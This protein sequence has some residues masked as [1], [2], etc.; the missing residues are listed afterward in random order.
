MLI[1]QI[2]PAPRSSQSPAYP[3]RHNLH[4]RR[5]G[6]SAPGLLYAQNGASAT[7]TEI[8]IPICQSVTYRLDPTVDVPGTLRRR[9][10]IFRQTHDLGRFLRCSSSCGP[11]FRRPGRRGAP[12]SL[13]TSGGGPCNRRSTEGPAGS[14]GSVPAYLTSS[15]STS[16]S[17][18]A[19]GGITPPAPREP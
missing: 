3:W 1:E 13:S 17:R 2:F 5:K 7:S 12:V 9:R 18:V 14:Q 19:S 4:F 11:V 6:H 8:V 16:K 15:S 10:A